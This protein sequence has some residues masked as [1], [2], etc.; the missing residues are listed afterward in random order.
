MLL[1]Y[2][3]R[4]L[5]DISVCQNKQLRYNNNMFD[6]K[7]N[8]FPYPADTAG[9]YLEV[10]M[11]RGIVFDKDYPYVDYSKGFAFKRFWVRLLLRLIVFPMSLIRMGIRIKG[12]ENL[13][14]N[15]KI[16][17]QGA[18]TIA[19]HVHMWD[20]ICVMK[21]L[22][23]YKWPYLLS[24]DKNVNGDSGPLVRMVGGIPIPEH[25]NLATVS[26]LKATKKLLADGN[27]LHIYPEGSMWEY[28]A[29]IRPFKNGAASFAIK[30]NKPI[31]PMAFTYRKPNWIRRKIFKQIALFTLHIGEPLFANPDLQQSAQIDDLTTRAHQEMCRLAGQRHNIYSPIYNNSKRIDY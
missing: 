16:I 19:N 6:P 8:K 13:R 29:P 10:E 20:Y 3:K 26:F 1:L 31:I 24:W 17:S 30:N 2:Q 9:H 21:A 14:N 28:Y 25:D 18:I 7:N 4:R 15:K 11:D 12:K 27:F 22:H 23:N 5:S